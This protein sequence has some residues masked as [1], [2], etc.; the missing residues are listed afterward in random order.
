MKLRT[1]HVWPTYQARRVGLH[2]S[3]VRYYERLEIVFP[4]ERKSGR[5]RKAILYLPS[6]VNPVTSQ[7]GF[8]LD[9]TSTLDRANT[10]AGAATKRKMEFDPDRN[11]RRVQGHSR[12]YRRTVAEHSRAP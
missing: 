1:R 5:R 2:P 3:V 12:L 7:T 6:G 9:K 8:A 10:A 4:A 11:E